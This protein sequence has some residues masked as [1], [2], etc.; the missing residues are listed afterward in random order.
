M[1][2]RVI[3]SKDCLEEKIINKYVTEHLVFKTIEKLRINSYLLLSF[4]IKN[5]AKDTDKL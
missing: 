2:P 1:G 4:T 5:C 3:N